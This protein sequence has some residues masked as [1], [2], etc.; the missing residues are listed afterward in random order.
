M[1]PVHGS[2]R[3][4]SEAG[5]VDLLMSGV[6]DQACVV[7]ERHRRAVPHGVASVVA[8]CE[9]KFLESSFGS[10][11]NDYGSEHIV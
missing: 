6:L 10:D 5:R 1:T 4:L 7:M 8:A 11:T 9:T 3:V 2:L